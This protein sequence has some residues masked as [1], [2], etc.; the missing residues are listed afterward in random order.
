MSGKTGSE[1]AIKIFLFFNKFKQKYVHEKVQLSVICS[2]D[3]HWSRLH[4]KRGQSGMV[5][6]FFYF[7]SDFDGVFPNHSLWTMQQK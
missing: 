2:I 7:S 5:L 1:T 3:L 4:E 6:E